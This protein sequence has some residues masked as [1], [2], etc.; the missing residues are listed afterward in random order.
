MEFFANTVWSFILRGSYATKT[1]KAFSKILES[2][3]GVGELEITPISA[4]IARHLGIDLS[5]EG[6]AARN[7]RGIAI[8]VHGAPLSG[9]SA[10]AASIAKK[11][12]IALLNVDDIIKEAITNGTSSAGVFS[13]ILSCLYHNFWIE[14]LLNHHCIA[15]KAMSYCVFERPWKIMFERSWKTMCLKVL[16]RDAVTIFIINTHAVFYNRLPMKI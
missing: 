5:A 2:D 8:I 9:K 1:F 6:K 13:L 11:Y 4:A 15:L 7:R 3:Y 12:N 10:T 16:T 14:L